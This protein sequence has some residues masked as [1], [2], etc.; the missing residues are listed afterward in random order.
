MIC[1]TQPQPEGFAEVGQLLKI[2]CHYFLYDEFFIVSKEEISTL[3]TG[4]TSF[5][6]VLDDYFYCS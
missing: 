4:L 5:L 6:L 2:T 3:A 1:C